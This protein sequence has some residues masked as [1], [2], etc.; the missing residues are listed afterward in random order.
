MPPR[1]R[2]NTEAIQLRLPADL[3]ARLRKE[4]DDRVVSPSW[5]AERLITRG[6]D[7]LPPLPADD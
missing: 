6:L 4:A 1:R 3:V 7:A 5:L 2:A